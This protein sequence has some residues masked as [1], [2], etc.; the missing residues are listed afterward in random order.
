MGISDIWGVVKVRRN[1]MERTLP[2]S[3]SAIETFGNAIAGFTRFALGLFAAWLVLS[4]PVLAAK[5]SK[6]TLEIVQ[7]R[8]TEKKAVLIDVREEKEW[9]QGHLKAAKLLPLSHLERGVSKEKLKEFIPKDKIVYLHCASG[10]RC[11]EAA[12]LL[13]ELGFEVRPL[14]PG[15]DAF[16]EAGFEEVIP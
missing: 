13:T 4:T 3:K 15:Y 16:V 10:A 8:V 7:N 6:D 9:K 5:H 12:E 1:A 14:K 11:I 2:H